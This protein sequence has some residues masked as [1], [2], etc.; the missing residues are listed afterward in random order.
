MQHGQEPET[1]D[2]YAGLG[3]YLRRF[4]D[5]FKPGALTM[6]T[7]AGYSTPPG[8][9][10]ERAAALYLPRLLLHFFAAGLQRTFLYQLMDGGTGPDSE[11]HYG[12]IY[13]DGTPK[14]VFSTLV[15]LTQALADPGPPFTPGQLTVE[16][17]PGVRSV[18]LQKRN[19]RYFLAL[20]RP[21][22]CWDP[23]R[24]QDIAQTP[25]PA[26]LQ[27]YQPA[28]SVRLPGGSVHAGPAVTVTVG[29]EVLLVE[30]I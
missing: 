4:R 19:G 5:P 25:R 7:E 22:R 3:W 2:D 23:V 26:T 29:A 10:S 30:V 21:E 9:I 12:M 1:A 20:W 16:I 13:P 28:R 17:E 15:A 6:A 14:P 8:G 27:L 18:L 24:H 11:Q